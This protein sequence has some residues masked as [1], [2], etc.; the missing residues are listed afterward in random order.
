MTRQDVRRVQWHYERLRADHPHLPHKELWRQAEQAAAS[1]PD[2]FDEEVW[3]GTVTRRRSPGRVWLTV[4][5]VVLVAG[6]VVG[7][8]FLYWGPR[9]ERLA[10]ERAA[11]ATPVG[12]ATFAD[13]LRDPE[14]YE[15]QV[16]TLQGILDN[17]FYAPEP[18]KEADP[19]PGTTADPTTTTTT[20]RA[21]GTSITINKAYHSAL[22]HPSD[23]EGNDPWSLPSRV[24]SL[25]FTHP[26]QT[27]ARDGDSVRVTCRIVGLQGGLFEPAKVVADVCRDLVVLDD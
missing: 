6:L 26:T 16:W 14:S 18:V 20:T 8:G 17:L 21:P 5:A 4:L 12:T 10:T 22:E 1:N 7:A 9:S 23:F 11:V 24:V 19:S 25:S 2:V 15:G 3:R 13:I 27:Q